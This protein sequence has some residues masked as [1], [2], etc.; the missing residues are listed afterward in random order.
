MLFNIN[1]YDLIQIDSRLL[2]WVMGYQLIMANPLIGVG[3]GNSPFYTINILEST[4]YILDGNFYNMRWVPMNTYIQWFAE[5]GII[6]F[7]FLVLI[8]KYSNDRFF[9]SINHEA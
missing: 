6:G 4:N 5:T 9:Y 1:S 2:S 7:S 3:L 8:N